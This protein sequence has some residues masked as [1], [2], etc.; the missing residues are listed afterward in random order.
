MALGRAS[1]GEAGNEPVQRYPATAVIRF[2]GTSTL[3]DFGGELGTQPFVL[4][5]SNGTWS[6]SAA[7]L[8]GQMATASEG[9]DRNMH[10][11]LATNEYPE[12]R[13]TVANAPIP[14]G[15]APATNVILQLKIRDQT[16][17]LPVVVQE[18]EESQ[19]NI[20][21]RAAWQVSLKQY[22][23]K[24]PSVMAVVRV[25]DRVKLEADVVATRPRSMRSDA[26]SP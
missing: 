8:S 7:V 10:R 3:H 2:N 14:N 25:G 23:L 19:E 4:I 26:T 16:R 13:G 5:V 11:M 22:G 20:R 12:I 17:A 15:K 6:A 24:A 18:W 9:R 21:F 1:S